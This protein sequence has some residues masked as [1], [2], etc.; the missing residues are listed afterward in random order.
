MTHDRLITMEISI[1]RDGNVY[2][3]TQTHG[4]SWADVYRGTWAIKR[5]LDRLVDEQRQCPFHPKHTPAEPATAIVLTS[6]RVKAP[7]GF[8]IHGTFPSF[9]AAVRH[10][11]KDADLGSIRA[12]KLFAEWLETGDRYET[13]QTGY[14]SIDEHWCASRI[15]VRG[16]DGCSPA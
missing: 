10:I 2:Q 13:V 1:D 9:A 15:P 4:N 6:Q 3:D 8:E 12:G 11:I 16:E 7:D 14:G 5:E